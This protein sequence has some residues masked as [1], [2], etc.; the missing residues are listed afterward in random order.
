M[1]GSEIS[2]STESLDQADPA[3]LAYPV[4][5]EELDG[6]QDV[7]LAGHEELD[8]HVP[9]ERG[10]I[11]LARPLVD[12][13]QELLGCL[14]ERQGTCSEMGWEEKE[15]PRSIPAHGGSYVVLRARTGLSSTWQTLQLLG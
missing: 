2:R 11:V 3:S 15:C 1:L 13:L 8:G 6:P 9:G 7:K 12:L 5:V 14:R 10:H 4:G